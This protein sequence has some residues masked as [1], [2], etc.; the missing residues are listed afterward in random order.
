M[1]SKSLGIS[2]RLGENVVRST[3]KCNLL[4]FS[5]FTQNVDVLFLLRYMF[6]ICNS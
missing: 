6:Y 1:L 2:K 5:M 3:L 4:H